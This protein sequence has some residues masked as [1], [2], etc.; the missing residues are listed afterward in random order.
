MIDGGISEDYIE[1]PYML[2]SYDF[3]DDIEMQKIYNKYKNKGYKLSL[4]KKLVNHNN[5]DLNIMQYWF[6]LDRISNKSL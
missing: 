3:I 5:S 1:S 6:K 4:K 2:S